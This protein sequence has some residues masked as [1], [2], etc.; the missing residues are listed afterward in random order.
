M[1][2]HKN[3]RNLC[4]ILVI[5][6]FSDTIL[7]KSK[8]VGDLKIENDTVNFGEVLVGTS[9][10]ISFDLTNI[11]NTSIPIKVVPSCE[12]CTKIL[13][14]TFIIEVG[15][16]S[17]LNVKLETFE[18][19]GPSERTLSLYVGNTMK[20]IILRMKGEVFSPIKINPGYI[21]FP[22]SKNKD[23]FEKSKSISN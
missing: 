11:G 3:L 17:K 21:Y 14:S 8:I 20:R 7:A 15:K 5:I 12:S 13:E 6:L 4:V 10:P 19:T 22:K 23:L 9:V 2:L 1:T 18:L 16:T